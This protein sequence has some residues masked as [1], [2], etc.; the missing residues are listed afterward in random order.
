ME[1]VQRVMGMKDFKRFQNCF[2]GFYL[3]HQVGMRKPDREIFEF[4]LNNNNLRADETLFIDDT[5]EHTESAARLG[6][7]TW[8]L[9]VGQEEILEL[10]NW[11]D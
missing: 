8:N 9:Q 6:I 1:Q 11:L 5:R 7:R 2:H 4:V 10:T 3:S